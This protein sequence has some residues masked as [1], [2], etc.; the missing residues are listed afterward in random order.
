MFSA[1]LTHH[2]LVLSDLSLPDLIFSGSKQLSTVTDSVWLVPASPLLL[3]WFHT[4]FH[5]WF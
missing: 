3:T 1:E 4:N 2:F 5:N